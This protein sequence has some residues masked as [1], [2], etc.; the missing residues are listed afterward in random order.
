MYTVCMKNTERIF[1]QNEENK[2]FL[3]GR[4]IAKDTAKL[5]PG[6]GVNLTRFQLLP[7]LNE[8]VTRF[9]Y[10]GRVMK[11]KGIEQ[12]L[13]AAMTVN[14]RY[15]ETEFHV[16]GPCEEDYK[17]VLE[18]YQQKGYIVYHGEQND[19]RRFHLTSHCTIHPSYYPEGMSNVLLESAALGR[20]IITTDRSGC[21]EI[22]DHGVNG[23][24]VEPRSC[25]DLIE[26]IERFLS[27]S[28]EQKKQMGLAGR[29]KVEKEFDRQIV[30][31][32]YLKELR[33][34]GVRRHGL[35]KNRKESRSEV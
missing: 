6:S 7:Y 29:A 10:V 20:P 4:G 12:F 18:D 2:K 17:D 14:K 1:L 26:N 34:I 33:N 31:E 9:L 11:K 21:R 8:D 3:Q 35:Q 23:Y 28:Y 27:L 30:V 15:R 19:V 24:V 13:E 22:V 32:A 25:H 5:I 16:V